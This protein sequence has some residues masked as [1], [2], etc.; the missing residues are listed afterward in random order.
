MKDTQNPMLRPRF[1]HQGIEPRPLVGQVKVLTTTLAVLLHV[2]T[3]K[4]TQLLTINRF[5]ALLF[6]LPKNAS[7]GISDLCQI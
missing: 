5:F 3:S 6:N 4:R 1:L 7:V 2:N